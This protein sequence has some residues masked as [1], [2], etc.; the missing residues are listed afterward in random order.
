LPR[1]LPVRDLPL[2]DEPLPW[3][4]AL[5]SHLQKA[6]FSEGLRLDGVFSLWH[7]SMQ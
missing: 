7:P 6:L 5:S 2:S 3:R 4:E 1:D